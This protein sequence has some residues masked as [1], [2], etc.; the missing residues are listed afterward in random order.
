MGMNGERRGLRNR[1]VPAPV[2]SLVSSFT[3]KFLVR[4][5]FFAQGELFVCYF[6]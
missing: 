4:G 1:L 6:F 2:F 3:R 5:Y